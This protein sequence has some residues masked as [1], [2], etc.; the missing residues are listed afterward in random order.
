MSYRTLLT[1]K[2]DIYPLKK[3]EE[4]LGYGIESKGNNFYYDKEPDYK[5]VPCYFSLAG[6]RNGVFQEEPNNK[7]YE[8]YNVHFM[9]GT[10]I[11]VNTK[12]KKDGVF[13]KLEVPRTIKNH[14]IEVT[15]VR[16]GNL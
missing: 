13:Y 1:D 15:A 11:K 4:S 14:H 5:E 3:K 8:S 9:I 7:I 10:P 6:L 2:C 12:V 16:E